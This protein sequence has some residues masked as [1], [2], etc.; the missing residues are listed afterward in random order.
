[1]NQRISSTKDYLK[2]TKPIDISIVI[3]CNSLEFIPNLV[4]SLEEIN[5]A[6]INYEALFVIDSSLNSQ[7]VKDLIFTLK[8][9]KILVCY[10]KNL[11][12]AL[13]LAIGQSSGRY[14]CR[15]DSDDEITSMRLIAQFNFLEKNKNYA[16]VGGQLSLIDRFSNK[17]G[18]IHY[19][20]DS[21][22]VARLL[23][24]ECCVPHPGSMIRKSNLEKV[25]GYDTKFLHAED[26]ELW[27]RLLRTGF[28]GNLNQIV[29]RYRIHQ[30]QRTHSDS[31]ARVTFEIMNV[32]KNY[33]HF[34]FDE[35][36]IRILQKNLKESRFTDF[37]FTLYSSK[38]KQLDF[39]VD[40]IQGR[41]LT[42]TKSK[43]HSFQHV[44]RIILT[45]FYRNPIQSMV[46]LKLKLQVKLLRIIENKRLVDEH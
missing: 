11:P 15:I 39:M 42:S 38:Q 1:M 26:W 3:P 44:V 25:G 40:L 20:C 36:K 41:Y 21:K 43:Q 8:T 13:N 37:D 9:K 27:T 34:S 10:L 18:I 23:A 33:A 22:L 4:K 16:A 2:N 6:D 46:Y 28:I 29:T 24:Y 7:S 35:A 17:L 31:L 12:T 32:A 5:V 45:I 19:P 14:L 30:N